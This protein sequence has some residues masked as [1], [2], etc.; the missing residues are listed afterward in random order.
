MVFNSNAKLKGIWYGYQKKRRTLIIAYSDSL[1]PE[2]PKAAKILSNYRIFNIKMVT[3]WNS[4]ILNTL[5]G[6]IKQRM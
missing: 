2:I 3:W 6:W 1:G 5:N 4:N